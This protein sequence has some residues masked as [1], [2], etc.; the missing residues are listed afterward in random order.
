[1]IG[2]LIIFW[3]IVFWAAVLWVWLFG[4]PGFLFWGAM[5]VVIAMAFSRYRQTRRD[6]F[7]QLLALAAERQMPL[8][9][10]AAA[11]AK[12]T[13]GRRFGV[14][15]ARLEAGEPLLRAFYQSGSVVS[16]S[17]AAAVIAG[18][19]SGALGPAL[20]DAVRAR[21]SQI[22]I[23]NVAG[24]QLLYLCMVVLVAAFILT[25]YSLK[26][27]PQMVLIFDDFASELPPLTKGIAQFTSWF[28]GSGLAAWLAV[29]LVVA[30]FLILGLY[31]GWIRF[32]VPLVGRLT[33]RLDAAGVLR[34]LALP[35]ARG[36]SFEPV[37]LALSARHP[38]RAVRRK[39]RRAMADIDAGREWVSA[40]LAR[41]LI[42]GAEAAVLRAAERVGN[43]PWALGE[44]AD[45]V[46]RRLAYRL[47][48]ISQVVFPL[49]VLAMG[50]VVMVFVVGYFLPLVS[51]VSNMAV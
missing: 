6:V 15:A 9:P 28:G 7:V 18:E 12:E 38:N 23:W 16:P 47:R 21:R 44:M 29:F 50:A 45:S 32:R 33:D 41:G 17:L 11:F 42:R 31:I 4:G 34:A 46:E 51:L 19:K 40:L 13:H 2:K 1:M 43:L 30:V 35:A 3:S 49:A 22:S 37:L 27:M 24:E 5:L 8:A 14:L 25:F 20:Q 36:Q 39:L 26:I 10:L 48:A